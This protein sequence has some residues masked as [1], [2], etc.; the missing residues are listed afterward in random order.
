[1][2]NKKKMRELIV[3]MHHSIPQPRY[4]GPNHNCIVMGGPGYGKTR[5][6]TEVNLALMKGTSFIINDSK[7]SLV[8]KYRGYLERMGY[9]VR[10]LN[11][12]RP[13]TDGHWNMF[14]YI[15]NEQ[16]IMSIAHILT[17]L[18]EQ[19]QGNNKDPFWDEATQMRMAAFIAFC[20][21]FVPKGKMTFPT[22]VFL[23]D[24]PMRLL[25][26]VP[27]GKEKYEE[28]EKEEKK[29]RSYDDC[30]GQI[31]AELG[32]SPSQKN[33]LESRVFMALS[34]LFPDSYAL[35]LY[36]RVAQSPEK[37]WNTIRITTFSKLGNFDAGGVQEMLSSDDVDIESIGDRKTALFVCVSDCDRALDPLANIFYSQ[38]IKVLEEHADNDCP[39]NRLP[40]DVTF[41]F[42]DF[43]TS[44]KIDDFPRMIAAF[45]SRGMSAILLLQCESQLESFYSPSD[46]KAIIACCSTYVYLGTMDLPTAQ[47]MSKRMNV[48]LEK[49]MNVPEGMCYVHHQGMKPFMDELF[50]TAAME[51]ELGISQPLEAARP[52]EPVAH[53][54][55][56]A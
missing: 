44:V 26:F 25:D 43:A 27:G 50:D 45:R 35:K 18:V 20:K 41:L 53:E 28:L 30:W 55:D 14:K 47:N 32:M 7:G 23:L 11:F 54:K 1:M 12:A 4:G 21:E 51:K 3:S 38:A 5:Y 36:C 19:G 9:E 29:A 39:E 24:N 52:E 56:A 48:P 15:R 13:G 22:L 6:F 17:Y 10:V 49:A 2:Y 33:C 31:A 37:T 34:R 46:A 40:I 16:D 42:D 8:K